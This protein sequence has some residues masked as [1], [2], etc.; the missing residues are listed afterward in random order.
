MAEDDV[1]EVAGSGAVGGV[2]GEGMRGSVS[3]ENGGSDKG[4]SRDGAACTPIGTSDA[5]NT[6]TS[7]R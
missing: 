2:N 7:T 1:E 3:M 6:E 5:A 4:T